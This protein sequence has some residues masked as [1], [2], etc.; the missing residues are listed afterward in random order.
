ML[1]Q[2]TYQISRYITKLYNQNIHVDEWNERN[3]LKPT[4][5]YSHLTFVTDA[6]NNTQWKKTASSKS[7]T[8][9]TEYPHLE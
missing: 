5:N 9:E 4:S 3:D 1:K 8:R 6:K 7:D 2:I